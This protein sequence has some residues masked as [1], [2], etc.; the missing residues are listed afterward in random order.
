MH[1]KQAGA[2]AAGVVMLGAALSGAVSAGLD[3][4][5][6]AKSFF[7]DAN[8]NPIVQVVVGE[9]G[10]ATDAVAAGNIAA[11]VGNLA[12]AS[13]VKTVGA[14]GSSSGQVKIGVSA[15]GATGKFKQDS[16][17]V[18]NSSFYA[19]NDGL[20]FN[21]VTEKYERGEFISYSLACDTQERSEAG[22]LK[23]AEYSN[24]HCLFCQTLCL[25]SLENP[26]H[27][28]AES[29]TV[30]YSGM[31]W[32][33]DG[34]GK[35]D[36]EKLILKIE[37][38]KVSYSV[39]N[40]EV[41]MSSKITLNNDDI[42]FE[43][44]GKMILFGE[45]YYVK[46]IKGNDKIYLAKG[47]ILD[48]ISSEGYTAEYMGYKFKIDHLIYS[49]EYQ[50]AGILLD[51]E[52][53]DGTVV[54]TQVSKM[55]NGIVD[56]IE[57]SGVY[58]EE[59]DQVATA[60]ILVYDTTTNVLLEDGKDMELGGEV[61]KYWRVDFSTRT[62]TLTAGT[63][64][65]T[66]YDGAAGTLLENITIQ[67]RHSIELE[68]GESLNFPST[69]K[70]TFDGYRS[71]DFRTIPVSGEGE[72]NIKIE[73]DGNY[74][75]LLSFTDDGGN[76]WDD[77]R[78]DNGPFSKGD[79]FILGGKVY[80]YDDSEEQAD[81]VTMRVTFKDLVD[82]GKESFDL[83][84]VTTPT[85]FYLNTTAFEEGAEN[86][87]RLKIEPD[88][89]DVD[90]DVF[91][92]T[93]SL[94]GGS[95]PLLYDAGD[96]YFVT[97]AGTVVNSTAR[98]AAA[99][100]DSMIGV[101]SAQ[102]GVIQ[103]FELN[104]NDITIQVVNEDGVLDQNDYGLT[105]A[106]DLD[107]TLILVSNND[108][109][110]VV[111]DMYD[112]NYND[113]VDVYY[114]Q[115][116]AA[117]LDAMPWNASTAAPTV[118]LKRDTD[119]VLIL[120]ESGDRINVDWGADYRIDSVEI[121]HPQE[122]VAATTFLGTSEET[123]VLESVITEADVGT[124][125]NAGCCTFTVEE[126]GVSGAAAA[127]VTE[128]TVQDVPTNLVV[129]EISAD[130]SKNLVIVGGPAVN[131]MTTVTAE[132]IASASQKYIVKKDGR[133]LIVAGWTAADTVDAGNALIDWMKANVH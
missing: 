87:D 116:V 83:V 78:M 64:D 26:T 81:S 127:T 32:Y 45:E 90:S 97:S 38:K 22:V 9:K 7:Y 41:P 12:Y 28:M 46:D 118:R 100:A 34:L 39:E 63:N 67:Y 3:D 56:D 43:W 122:A 48:D 84:A 10:M 74:E 108:G 129:P 13:A 18:L 75:L 23:E 132:Q 65:V 50:V 53:P 40:G 91:I 66:E 120:P 92:G 70:L 60:S 6:L 21:S 96:V 106:T 117:D 14:E 8:Y 15:I 125:K 104:G 128:V 71:T 35:D 95:V 52:K 16:N 29:I 107:D 93:E 68:E 124:T 11:T 55:A 101:T 80:E 99:L 131:G 37:S 44:R 49:A 114:D 17:T 79:R 54:Q 123:T 72:G 31:V 59:A 61:K 112:R 94:S 25:A 105:S 24:V 19:D 110:K 36:S 58:A 82:G 30:D 4:T 102:V 57:I 73:K 133:K 89:V 130:T 69:Y 1:V 62:G 98:N 42:D 2:I 103:K 47:A 126:F 109:E 121:L 5:G 85:T 51:V 76:R 77:I 111:I 119:T 86:D 115:T 27:E 113:S 20:V 33:E 88:A